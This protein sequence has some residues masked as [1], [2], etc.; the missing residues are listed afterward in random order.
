MFNQTI[1]FYFIF[2]NMLLLSTYLFRAAYNTEQFCIFKCYSNFK[3]SKAFI[4]LIISSSF[5]ICR[6]SVVQ[7]SFQKQIIIKD[8]SHRLSVALSFVY[9]QSYLHD[10]FRS[11]RSFK[12]NY[13]LTTLLTKNLLSFERKSR[14]EIIL[15]H[16]FQIKSTTKKKNGCFLLLFTLFLKSI[17]INIQPHKIRLAQDKFTKTTAKIFLP[18]NQ[19]FC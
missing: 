7:F 1:T 11:I 10:I 14:S 8:L 5:Q 12:I 15:K 13:V 2:D 16:Y 3:Q 19:Q 17:E 9:F 6:I 18:L 4:Y